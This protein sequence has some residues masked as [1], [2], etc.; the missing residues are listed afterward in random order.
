ME[1]SAP[2]PSSPKNQKTESGRVDEQQ[3]QLIGAAEPVEEKPTDDVET[4]EDGDDDEEEA[5][6]KLLADINCSS[7][8]IIVGVAK[9][10]MDSMFTACM[11]ASLISSLFRF[12]FF[13]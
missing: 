8:I 5:R 10:A 9:L 11:H 3:Q 7:R 4:W 6:N 12:C 13:F 1:E 2:A